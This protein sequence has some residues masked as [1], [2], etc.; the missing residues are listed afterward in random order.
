MGKYMKIIDLIL[1]NSFNKVIRRLLFLYPDETVNIKGYRKIYKRMKLMKFK[2]SKGN[3]HIG[4][5]A[6]MNFHDI[7]FTQK[8]N[9]SKYSLTFIPQ[10]MLVNMKVSNETLLK[11]NELNIISHFLYKITWWGF[12]ERKILKEAKENIKNAETQ[13]F[14]TI[15]ELKEILSK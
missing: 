5:D 8:E 13:P 14:S 2:N 11:Y 10:K 12:D 4:Y 6:E 15:E 3:I 9:N 7:Y 1:K